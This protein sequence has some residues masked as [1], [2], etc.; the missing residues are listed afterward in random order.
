M[1]SVQLKKGMDMQK[2]IKV[3]LVSLIALLA[4]ACEK[5]APVAPGSPA[6]PDNGGNVIVVN[7]LS[8]SE[9]KD[10]YPILQQFERENGV[11]FAMTYKGS[12]D[13]MM[14][15]QKGAEMPYDFVWLASDI[16]ISIGDRQK[17]VKNAESIMTSPVV[18][19]VK[20]SKAKELGWVNNPNVKIKDILEAVSASKIR[21]AMTSATQSNTGASGL[22]GFYSAMAGSPEVLT[23]ANLNDPNVQEQTQKLLNLVNRS[24]G[25]SGF[26]VDDLVAHPERYDSIVNYEALIVTANQKLVAQG[27]EPLYAIYPSD[28]TTVANFPLGF[29]SHGDPNKE[30][31]FKKLQA[32]LKSDATQKQILALGRR[33]QILGLKPDAADKTVFNPSWGIDVTKS[34]SAI[35]MPPAD[36]IKAGLE[37][38]Q[39]SL[40]KPSFSIFV[41]D[42]SGSML[43]NG[44]AEQLRA[45]MTLLLEPEEAKRYLLQMSARDTTVIFPYDNQVYGPFVIK[46]N[47]P[48]SLRGTLSKITGDL[49]GGGTSTH[50]A[51]STAFDYLMEHRAEL[52]GYL[53]AVFLMTDGDATDDIQIF[54]DKVAKLGIGRD[55][56]IYAITFGD[57]VAKDKINAIIE[58]TSGKVFDGTQDLVGRFREVKGYN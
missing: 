2:L 39:T 58:T 20:L 43:H 10:L 1:C 46:G 3:F 7:F 34:F 40:R 29:V 47:D 51:L 11:K 4:I 14:A 31:V 41:L 49:G 15:L 21:F 36:V 48:A 18:D 19:A 26:L 53:P 56:P 52:P 54:K 30:A 9:N 24:S 42:Y 13:S 6:A 27:E 50:Q 55:I 57:Q 35:I 22:F 16:W 12:V 5:R 8:G 45:A 33:T 17:V 32:F 37:L 28:G 44:G 23:Q 25:S 38:Y